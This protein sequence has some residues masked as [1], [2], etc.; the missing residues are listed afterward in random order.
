MWIINLQQS[1][2]VWVLYLVSGSTRE[3]NKKTQHRAQ[4]NVV[5]EFGLVGG[6]ILDGSISDRARSLALGG[7]CETAFS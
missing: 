5:A 4:L 7:C 1:Q 6:K 2:A 3:D